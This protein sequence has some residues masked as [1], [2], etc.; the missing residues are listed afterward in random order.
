[1]VWFARNKVVD[2]CWS[3]KRA[4]KSWRAQIQMGLHH[5]QFREK[6]ISLFL[7]Q[8]VTQV[9]GIFSRWIGGRGGK[10]N[11]SL[12]ASLPYAIFNYDFLFSVVML[13]RGNQKAALLLAQIYRLDVSTLDCLQHSHFHQDV[14]RVLHCFQTVFQT[15]HSLR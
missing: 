10:N 1:M 7:K 15:I 4:V 11:F 5:I 2:L 13:G 8:L 3:W 9:N 6:W 12:L 14:S